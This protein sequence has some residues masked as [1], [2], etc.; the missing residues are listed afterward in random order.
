M[1]T[2][3]LAGPSSNLAGAGVGIARVISLS[4]LNTD[5]WLLPLLSSETGASGQDLPTQRTPRSAPMGFHL[6]LLPVMCRVPR[7]AVLSAWKAQPPRYHISKEDSFP[8]TLVLNFYYNTEIV[9]LWITVTILVSLAHFPRCEQDRNHNFFIPVPLY[10]LNNTLD[11]S[12][13]YSK[14]FPYALLQALLWALC[15]L[16]KSLN[17]YKAECII[18]PF[19]RW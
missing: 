11:E 6:I 1:R 12:N 18:V 2:C 7:K 10:N 17:N 16:L 5:F 13:H 14:P 3:T 4:L 19:C 8:P 9:L 15:K